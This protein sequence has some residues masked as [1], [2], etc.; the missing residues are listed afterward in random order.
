[1]ATV[2]DLKKQINRLQERVLVQ[3]EVIERLLDFLRDMGY[4]VSTLRPGKKI[5][6]K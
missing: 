6:P 4:E 3:G 1:M 5:K 2:K